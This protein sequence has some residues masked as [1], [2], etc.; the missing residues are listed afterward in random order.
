MRFRVPSI[1]T[2]RLIAVVADSQKGRVWRI[3]YQGEH[4][5]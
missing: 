5:H 3:A 2:A 4:A 1:A